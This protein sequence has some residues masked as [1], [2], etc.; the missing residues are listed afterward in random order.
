MRQYLHLLCAIS[1]ILIAPQLANAKDMAI[2]DV[3]NS[4]NLDSLIINV[5]MLTGEAKINLNGN[6]DSI[7]SRHY[8]H[9]DNEKAFQF[10]KNKIQEYG[11]DTDSIVFSPSG[12]NLFGIKLGNKYPKRVVII[13]AHYD[14]L[15]LGE[16][17]PGADDNASGVAAVIEASRLLKDISLPYTVVFALWDEEE[18]GLLGSKVFAASFGNN[19]DT[20][21]G[22]I[23]LDMIAWDSNMDYNV[24]LHVRPIANSLDLAGTI[25]KINEDYQIGLKIQVI[26]P[27][28]KDSDYA[29]FWNNN[30]PAVGLNEEYI[31][32]DFNPTWHTIYDKLE[33]FNLDYFHKVSQLAIASLLKF[34]SD[35]S[36]PVGID[37]NLLL[38]EKILVY[39]NPFNDKINIRIPEL[40]TQF[41]K[42][43]IYDFSGKEVFNEEKFHNQ[44]ITLPVH[45]AKGSYVLQLQTNDHIYIQKIIRQ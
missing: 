40:D 19:N 28:S 32:Q 35:T 41:I 25:E 7:I 2:Q 18:R 9:N 8:L 30:L 12:K 13:G 29:S 1:F 43:T 37:E 34:A 10:L 24:E 26:N 17:A 4:V 33:S 31:G 42:L 11:Y 45:L 3:I 5:K 6:R 16:R 22:Y 38:S 20:L 39:P 21:K 15:P 44:T 14:N 36:L 23:N 27:G